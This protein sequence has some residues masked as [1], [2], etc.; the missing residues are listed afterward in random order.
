MSL[1]NNFP[2]VSPTL[3]LNFAAA[4]RLDSRVTFTRSST[5]TYTNQIGLI[6][7]AA[8]N[9]PRFDYNPSTLAARGLLIEESRTNLL[10]YSEDITQWSVA[11]GSR[12]SNTAVSPDGQTTADTYTQSTGGDYLY[13]SAAI[14]SSTTYTLS[15]FLKAGTKTTARLWYA[16]GGFGTYVF[17]DINL[18][19]GTIGSVSSGGGA[20]AAAASIQA[21]GNGWYRVALTGNLGA[22]TVGY[23][24]LGND[25]TSGGVYIWGAQLE[26]GSF[27]TSY[28]PTVAASVTRSADVASVN[29]LSPWFNA[30]E[31]TLFAEAYL[32]VGGRYAGLYKTG[33]D[34]QI[35]IVQLNSGQIN[36]FAYDTGAIQVNSNIAGT[37]FSTNKTAFAYK[38]NDYASCVNGSAVTT[39]T[40]ASVP[41]L[42]YA[43]INAYQISGPLGSGHIRRITYY[44][45]RL[46][47]AQLQ[48]LTL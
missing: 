14:S 33:S 46:T 3:N 9:E 36:F 6:Q 7:S 34:N 4:G 17:I 25:S 44:S 12:S 40:S 45:A 18:S 26:A 29:T 38:A 11:G 16:T 23:L 10:T 24:V 32:S 27:A 20:T 2:T 47:N 5:A 15:V 42:N 39:D 35:E 31:G 28:I 21:F 37:A 41:S 1:S 48:A 43:N 22:N 30:T 13:H 19:A 8:V